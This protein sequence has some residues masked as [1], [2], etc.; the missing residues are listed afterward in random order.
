[1]DQVI[2]GS[3]KQSGFAVT[4]LVIFA[5]LAL[6][7]AALGIYGVMSYLVAQRTNEIGI[8]MAL[9]ANRKDVMNLILKHGIMLAI[10]GV[11]IGI[12]ASFAL[13]RLMSDL[14]FGVSP[15]DPATFIV[16]PIVLIFVAF[17]S[18]FFP[19]RSATKVD[20]IVALKYE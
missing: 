18:C 13:T 14:L 17:I 2:Q 19:A 8:R 16:I 10:V 1:M 4:I 6:L 15:T 20:P 11:T 12:V 5:A 7:L 3:F 9:G